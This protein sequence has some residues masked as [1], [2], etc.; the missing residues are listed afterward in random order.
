MGNCYHCGD[1]IVT[2]VKSENKSFCCQGCASVFNIINGAGLTDYY[3]GEKQNPGISNKKLVYLDYLE[4]EDVQSKLITYKDNKRSV[5]KF[6]LPSIH[7]AS[8]VWLLERLPLLNKGVISSEIDFLSKRITIHF[9]HNQTNLREV[10]ELLLSIG[11]E[12]KLDFKGKKKRINHL[13]IRIGVA[14]FC[15]GNIMLLSFP[16][17]LDQNP[18]EMWKRF[19]SYLNL[20]LSIPIFT[21]CSM[22]FY[23]GVSSA[24]RAKKIS[25]DI[26]IVIGILTLLGRSV[27][28]IFILES[29]GYLDSLAG[30]LFF[31]LIGKWFQAKVF[32]ELSFEKDNSYYLPL[33]VLKK[34]GEDFQVTSLKEVEKGDFLRLRNGE[35]VPFKCVLN[36][37]EGVVENSFITGE[38][39]P[40]QL[41]QGDLVFCGAQVKGELI[42]VVVA[43]TENGDLSE[44][45]RESNKTGSEDS[46]LVSSRFIT[47]FTLAVFGVAIGAF[48]YWSFFSW[49]KAFLATTSV[50]IVACPCALALSAPTVYGLILRKF[51]KFGAYLK[52]AQAIKTLSKIKTVVFD[53]TGTI[54]NKNIELNW[55]GDQLGVEDQMAIASISQHSSHPLAKEITKRFKT[56]CKVD[57]FVED[58]G[59]GAS[60]IVEG[61]RYKIGSND[62]VGAPSTGVTS[63]YVAR[64]NQILGMFTMKLSLREN[65]ENWLK[66][67]SKT[68]KTFLL[69]GDPN[70]NKADYN[71]LFN[72]AQII[73]DASPLEKSRV[74][75]E[76]SELQPTL[77]VGDGINDSLAFD[78]ATLGLAV[79]EETGAFFPSCDGII[80]GEQLNNLP[81]LIDVAKYSK[82]VLI[83][84]FSFS[85]IYNSIGLY[86]AV[87]QQLTPLFAAILM[88]LS[89][90]S[91]VGLAVLLISLKTNKK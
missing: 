8:C 73:K 38:E 50:L 70:L 86:F 71:H 89:S 79:V 56:F 80:K 9:D 51:G 36:S 5:V 1:D 54:T 57:A 61:I 74:I 31:L 32:S 52:N 29:G 39:L 65:L 64:E 63:V 19:F 28:E 41:K 67:F 22:P 45:W 44:M 23:K 43:D 91:V 3:N 42:E 17:Y 33:A 47:I 46:S 20:I 7:C 4:S 6:V 83:A 66:G 58:L 60:G 69:S 90:V 84:C 27:Y 75:K 14:G 40:V 10:G 88:P 62:F 78:S 82:T 34:S 24:W 55:V 13:I 81:F 77:M 49:E 59:K 53:K 30:L 12:P 35:V 2:E 37:I 18:G 16:E 72:S 25:V 15:F 21:Y 87:T 48:V 26:L 85:I 68:F 76:Q 11:Y